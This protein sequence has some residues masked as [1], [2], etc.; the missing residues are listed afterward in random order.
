MA[1]SYQP[2]FMYI[3]KL[4]DCKPIYKEKEHKKEEDFGHFNFYIQQENYNGEFPF[5]AEEYKYLIG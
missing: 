1:D 5:A 2:I 4:T 3:E